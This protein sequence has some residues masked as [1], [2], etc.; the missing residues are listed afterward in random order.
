MKRVL[1]LALICLGG[2]FISLTI[3]AQTKPT[4]TILPFTGAVGGDE[5][6]ITLLFANQGDL[7][8]A[9]TVV[10]CTSNFKRITEETVFPDWAK[11]QADIIGVVQTELNADFTVIVRTEKIGTAHLALVSLVELKTLRHLDGEYRY[12]RSL[13][14]FRSFVPDIAAKLIQA[15]QRLPDQ[16][17]ELTILPFYTPVQGVQSWEV[18]ILVQLLTIELANSHK[19]T[20]LPWAL[21]IETLIRDLTIPYFGIIDPD[22]IKTIGI[23]THIPYVLTGDVLNLGSTKLFM[24]SIVDTEDANLV[25]GG[26]VEYKVISED[27]PVLTELLASLTG[28]EFQ[29]AHS[30]EIPEPVQEA[31]PPVAQ[32]QRAPAEQLVHIPEGLGLLGSPLTEIARDTDEVPHWV[33][34]SSSFYMGKYEVSQQEYGAVME[35]NPS[36]FKGDTF[37]VERVTWFD[38]IQYC[39][40]RSIQE[41]LT[42]V[43]TID[44]EK[45]IWNQKANGY[46][47][48]TEAEWEYACRAGTTTAFNMGDTID[49]TQSNYDGTHT[50]ANSSL[51]IYRHQTTAIGSFPPN[52]WGL[53]D[54]H[55]NVYEWCW[56]GYAAYGSADWVANR[57]IVR[58]GSW[59]SAPQYLRSANRVRMSPYTKTSYLG[60]R[61]VR[62]AE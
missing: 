32:K 55:G 8:T 62:A 53:Y 36:Y 57:R 50:Y 7:R 30:P 41:G 58:G 44:Q 43:Y 39:N 12:Y 49:P 51:G 37:P 2:I 19:Y 1:K 52:P 23:I 14:E 6:I 35:T 29:T 28:T 45:V 61:V 24:A 10:P 33:R 16:L 27:L 4:L 46:R 21:R 22:R 15:A 56:D 34:V 59:Y 18:D 40:L 48:P 13:S 11:T 54:M 26:D 60:F 5:E 38:V 20:V 17:P 47:L 25:S 31:S 9:F 3:E 42:P